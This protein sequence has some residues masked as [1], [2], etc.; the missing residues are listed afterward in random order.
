MDQ[1]SNMSKAYYKDIEVT[2]TGAGQ[3]FSVGS[4]YEPGGAV[5]KVFYNG[6]LQKVGE[7]YLEVDNYNIQFPDMVYEGDLIHLRIE[8]AGSGVAFV[9]DHGHV[10]REVMQ[11]VMDGANRSFITGRPPMEGS[12]C[13]F[14]NGLL[15]DPNKG[16]YVIRYEQP[17]GRATVIMTKA[18][19]VG[20][21]LL[22][23]YVYSISN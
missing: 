5:L 15:Q 14:L 12:E 16:D 4:A 11:G 19:A 7:T 2:S 17:V 13:V 6:T 3:V 18:P 20:D 1:L 23:N 21:S 8:G 10:F 22:V 9:S